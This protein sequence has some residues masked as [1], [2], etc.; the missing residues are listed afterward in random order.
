M[1]LY[2]ATA[3]ASD[4]FVVTVNQVIR[5]G[6]APGTGGAGLTQTNYMG[7]GNEGGKLVVEGVSSKVFTLVFQ[8][9][10]PLERT[11][12]S[13]TVPVGKYRINAGDELEFGSGIALG[14]Q[15][16]VIQ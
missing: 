16:I 5:L 9:G 14:D 4:R 7:T 13:G 12:E 3:V 6:Y 2:K 15:I 10:V 8:G 1:S 11:N